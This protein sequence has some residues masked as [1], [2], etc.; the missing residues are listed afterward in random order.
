MNCMAQIRHINIIV[1]AK[2][3]PTILEI[4]AIRFKSCSTAFHCFILLIASSHP[5]I[6]SQPK[7]REERE[8]IP[9]LGFSA[10]CPLIPLSPTPEIRLTPPSCA[11]APDRRGR[12]QF[13]TAVRR[14]KRRSDETD[15]KPRDRVSP[16]GRCDGET[17]RYFGG[18]GFDFS[19]SAAA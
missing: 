18:G 10:H 5:I 19:S 13:R 17:W 11:H 1:F 12:G 7:D 15:R 6:K 8:E 9:F 2:A 16:E 14:G 3:L 4:S